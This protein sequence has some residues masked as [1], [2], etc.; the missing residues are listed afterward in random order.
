MTNPWPKT[1]RSITLA[2]QAIIS[3][4]VQDGLTG[5]APLGHTAVRLLDRD[6]G[7]EYPMRGTVLADGHFAFFAMPE[8]AFPQ[9]V[10]R[11]YHLRV[12]AT[13][14]RYSTDAF[15][16]DIGPI[17]DQPTVVTVQVPTPGVPDL[18]VRLF[19][20]GGLPQTGI[21][22]TLDR[23]AVRLEGRVIVSTNPSL[24]VANA[25][26]QQDP[27][28]GPSTTTGSDGSFAFVAP[29]PIALSL[30]VR[31]SAASFENAIMT[32]EPDYTRPVNQVTIP[33]KPS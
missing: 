26:V 14:L 22:L 23:V 31:I 29:L 6:T 15:D 17:V 32:L 33:L 25:T 12:Q 2:S 9:L 30:Q 27:P 28:T 18:S 24:G 1:V 7:E 16:F 3:G 10:D 4:S 11:T 8:R 13:A 20:A 19:T 5:A 21:S